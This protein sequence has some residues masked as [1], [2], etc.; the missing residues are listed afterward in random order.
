MISM[1]CLFGETKKK[2]H[3]TSLTAGVFHFQSQVVEHALDL[4]SQRDEERFVLLLKN[5]IKHSTTLHEPR[6]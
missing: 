3:G 2:K 1:F 6:H 5:N 4:R